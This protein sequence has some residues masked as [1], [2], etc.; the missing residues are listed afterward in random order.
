MVRWVRE[1]VFLK[2]RIDRLGQIGVVEAVNLLSLETRH[3]G[4][5]VVPDAFVDRVYFRQ[6]SA[7]QRGHRY[8]F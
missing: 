1:N 5:T 3:P 4:H 8:T 2:P 7:E 6:Q